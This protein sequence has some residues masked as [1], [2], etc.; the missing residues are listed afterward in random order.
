MASGYLMAE[1]N[2]GD[3]QNLEK[4]DGDRHTWKFLVVEDA[5]QGNEEPNV[6]RR[7]DKII[8]TGAALAFKGLIL[9]NTMKAVTA[10]IVGA[11]GFGLF[12]A[13]PTIASWF[14]FLEGVPGYGKALFWVVFGL[15]VL[16]LV[17]SGVVFLHVN[18]FDKRFLKMGRVKTVLGREV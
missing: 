13:W 16:Q 7:F 15:V 5:L 18:L 6:Q 8:E 17:V 12:K 1:H 10:L 9:S 2:A 4:F 3:I 14:S 11:L